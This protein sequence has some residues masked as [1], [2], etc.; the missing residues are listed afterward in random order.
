[1]NVAV[2]GLGYMGAT[3]VSA[4]AKVA[5]ARVA[6]V[7]S[8]S[9]TKLSGDLS[10]I[11]G[12]LGNSGERLDFSGMR[13]YRRVEEA[14]AADDIEAID[15]CLPTDLHARTAITALRA[16]KHVLLEKPMALDTADADD[17]LRAAAESGRVLMVGHVLR[18]LPAYRAA[19]EWVAGAGRVHS[20][21]FRRRCAA[22]SWSAWLL[23]ER[24]SGGSV[25]D[26]LIHDTD[27]CISIWGMPQSVRATGSCDL[28]RGIDV[29]GAE[30]QYDGVGPVTITGGWHHPRAYPFSMEFTIVADA[31]T[32]EWSSADSRGL[33]L[34]SPDGESRALPL[35]TADP[36]EAE[37]RY[38]AECARA[39]R[40]PDFCPPSQ[41]RDAAALSRLMLRSREHNGQT[42]AV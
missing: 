13:K 31:G 18:F 41:S 34:Y 21:L 24:R 38:F 14:L 33:V 12:N 35:D 40:Q 22:P 30:L 39:G 5:D 42:S 16:G 3:H 20:A 25:C 11:E 1:M 28:S 32:L 4:W 27:Y 19:A 26:L 9:E 23:D 37:L 29:I 17:I 6:A 8:S 15:I 7:M 10:A 2:L 36:F